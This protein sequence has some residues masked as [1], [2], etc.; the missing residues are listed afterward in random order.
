MN[1][2]HVAYPIVDC[3]LPRNSGIPLVQ[4]Q[5]A[6]SAS[7][8][9][10]CMAGVNLFDTFEE[11]HME[12]PSLPR[13]NTRARARQHYANQAQLLAPR[14]FRLITFTNTQGFHVAP[15]QVTNHIHMVN[16]VI[17][18]DTGSSLEYLQLIKDK[19]TLPVCNKAAAKE[20]G[21]LSQGVGGRI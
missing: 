13:N 4:H 21:R 10:Q 1:P 15:K 17:N 5:S 12:T 14:I 7:Y 18:Q 2:V 16:D 20:C 6:A 19:T 11:E 8:V 3:T 9:P